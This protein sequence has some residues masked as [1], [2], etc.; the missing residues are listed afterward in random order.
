MSGEPRTVPQA[1]SLEALATAFSAAG[2]PDGE[3]A[4]SFLAQAHED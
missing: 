2:G 1:F 4:R 3:A